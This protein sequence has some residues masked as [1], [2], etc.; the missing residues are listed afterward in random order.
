MK[1]DRVREEG[2]GETMSGHRLVPE[3]FDNPLFTDPVYFPRQ[4]VADPNYVTPKK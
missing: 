2:V 3:G 1:I 4:R